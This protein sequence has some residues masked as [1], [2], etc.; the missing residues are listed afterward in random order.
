M[1]YLC[2]RVKIDFG[3]W[4]FCVVFGKDLLDVV[5][6]FCLKDEKVIE[7]FIYELS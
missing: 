4:F 5:F 2:N 3:K 6:N 7:G 1:F